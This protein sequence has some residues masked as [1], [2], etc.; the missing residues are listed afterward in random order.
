MKNS[1]DEPSWGPVLPLGGLKAFAS[2]L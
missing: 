1:H 2:A